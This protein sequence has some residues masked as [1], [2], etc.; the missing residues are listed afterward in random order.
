MWGI[1]VLFHDFMS[2]DYGVPTQLRIWVASLA[3]G[4]TS[5]L[6][7]I[8]PTGLVRFAAMLIATIALVSIFLP[9]SQNHMFFTLVAS[10]TALAALA[11]GYCIKGRNAGPASM[12]QAMALIR[13][14]VLIMYFFVVLHKLNYDYFNVEVSCAVSLCN[15][16][17]TLSGIK[18]PGAW[19]YVPT[20]W[21]VVVLEG[22]IP[23]L[24][25]IPRTRVLG[26]GIGLAFHYLLALHPNRFVYDYSAMMFAL[27]VLFLPDDFLFDLWAT[28]RRITAWRLAVLIVLG[29][30]VERALVALGLCFDPDKLDGRLMI[31]FRLIWMAMGLAAMALFC[32]TLYRRGGSEWQRLT[33]NPELA[34]P[35]YFRPALSWLMIFPVLLFFNGCCPY[36]GLKTAP[37]FSMF[38]NLRTEGGRTNH[39][40]M[41]IQFRLANY[42]EDLVTI[43]ESSEPSILAL[44]KPG[45]SATFFDLRTKVSS[46]PGA[47]LTVTYVRNGQRITETRR[48]NQGS[49]L[50]QK[51]PL[52]LRKILYFRPIQIGTEPQNCCW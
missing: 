50:F 41:P 40:F 51:P 31:W 6:V 7:V 38:S 19:I 11:W 5:L 20:I 23:I 45:Y 27:F 26:V 25:M 34:E 4:L 1:F 10:M 48:D 32:A 16:L 33:G 14:E 15:D 21:G 18:M 52:L 36:L 9:W 2:Q 35:S 12:S 46:V 44:H 22:L 28:V 37:T 8:K 17:E 47:D 13:V 24:L 3:V 42:Q 30:A 39:F 49:E 29:V 43:L